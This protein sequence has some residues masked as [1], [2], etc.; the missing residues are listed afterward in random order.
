[1]A[2]KPGLIIDVLAGRSPDESEDMPP[3]SPEEEEAEGETPPPRQNADALIGDIQAQ[4]ER[5]RGMMSELH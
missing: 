5:L 2:K 3:P 4:L 1:M